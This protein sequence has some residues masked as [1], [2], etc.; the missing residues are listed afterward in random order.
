MAEEDNFRRVSAK[1]EQQHSST[2]RSTMI[3]LLRQKSRQKAA[4]D[5]KKTHSE[6]V[7]MFRKEGTHL[8]RVIMAEED[9]FRRISA[10]KEQQQ[11]SSTKR[12]TMIRLLKQRVGKRLQK[13]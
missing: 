2:K 13:T 8:M 7:Q 10:Q 4:K 11:H 3:R 6:H 9:N 1:K 5:V 12:S